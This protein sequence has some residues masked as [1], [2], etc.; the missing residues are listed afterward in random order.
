MASSLD[1]RLA[2]EW[3]EWK[4]L[5]QEGRWNLLN[6]GLDGADSDWNLNLDWTSTW[7]DLSDSPDSDWTLQ[8]DLYLM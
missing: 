1:L 8:Y 3:A 7:L 4:M 2:S 5:R 6:L